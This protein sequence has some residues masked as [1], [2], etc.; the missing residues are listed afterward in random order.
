MV[1]WMDQKI[2]KLIPNPVMTFE[3]AFSNY[4]EFLTEKQRAEKNRLF[5]INFLKWPHFAFN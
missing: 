3:Q 4:R 1:S 5:F 2:I